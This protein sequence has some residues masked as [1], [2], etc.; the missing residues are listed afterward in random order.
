MYYRDGTLSYLVLNLC[1]LFVSSG[2]VMSCHRGMVHHAL[3]TMLAGRTAENHGMPACDLRVI[4]SRGNHN[5]NDNN[6]DDNNN[7][8]NME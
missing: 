2:L 6:N 3:P 7:N 1:W 4:E 5:N 8:K